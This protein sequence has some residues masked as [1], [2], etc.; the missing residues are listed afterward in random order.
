[1][2]WLTWLS[3]LVLLAG[4][5]FVADAVWRALPRFRSGPDVPAAVKRIDLVARPI[6]GRDDVALIAITATGGLDGASANQLEEAFA[7]AI[8]AGARFVL[9]DMTG[10][11]MLA[12][13]LPGILVKGADSLAGRGGGLALFGVNA[14]LRVVLEMLNFTAVLPVT[15]DAAAALRHLEERRA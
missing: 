6:P 12:S 9:V 14:K 8:A 7:Q 10:V 1:M 3:W 13:L 11:N 5:A 4:V 15:P 2:I